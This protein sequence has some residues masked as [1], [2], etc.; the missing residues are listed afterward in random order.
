MPTRATRY[1]YGLDWSKVINPQGTSSY[2]LFTD[3]LGRASRVDT[4]NSDAP[5]GYTSMTYAYN[6]AGQLESATNSLDKTHPWT[7]TYDHRGRTKTATDPDAGTTR[8]SYATSWGLDQSYTYDFKYNDTGM[9]EDSTLP[10]IGALAAEKL[11]VRYNKDGKQLSLSG[12]D[13]YGAETVYDSFGQVQRSTL[14]AQPYRVWT[15]NSY[16]DSSGELKQQSVYREG[17]A[18]QTVVPGNLVS[19]RF[20]PPRTRTPA[21]VRRTLT[22][23]ST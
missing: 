13:W 12:K 6:A 4:F 16:D 14:G 22:A 5:D 7:W 19:D 15:Q 20:G 9:L 10:K 23:R 3:A 17:T 11:V 8:T 2:R 21:P 1:E 18:D